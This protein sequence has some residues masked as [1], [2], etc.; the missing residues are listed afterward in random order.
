[1]PLNEYM[2]LPRFDAGRYAAIP[3]NH[4]VQVA[5]VRVSARSEAW[6]RRWLHCRHL[7][8]V[9]DPC[10]LEF[11]R[12]SHEELYQA[13]LASLFRSVSERGWQEGSTPKAPHIELLCYGR[14]AFHGISY[15]C[16]SCGSCCLVSDARGFRSGCCYFST[17]NFY[18]DEY[19]CRVGPLCR[20]PA[21]RRRSLNLREA[22][23]SLPVL[24]IRLPRRYSYQLLP[25][26]VRPTR[27]A[28][29][30]W[31]RR[32]LHRGLR[33]PFLG[34]ASPIPMRSLPVRPSRCPSQPTERLLPRTTRTII[35]T[36]LLG[37]VALKKRILTLI[38]TVPRDDIV[39]LLPFRRAHPKVGVTG[40]ARS[41][42]S[43]I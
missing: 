35:R 18:R 10:D 25:L 9:H 28:T 5:G 33:L 32:F 17:S 13:R 26:P 27:L 43:K 30:P 7:Q 14:D 41:R 39:G 29:S 24:R 38:R 31:L 15:S 11:L 37:A 36:M 42:T 22:C 1:M 4:T 3:A 20:F 12:T 6:R 2:A 16:G 21:L 19:S 23:S 40:G 34:Q 8:D